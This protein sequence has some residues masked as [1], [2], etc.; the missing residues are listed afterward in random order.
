MALHGASNESRRASCV[1]ILQSLCEP[2]MCHRPAQKAIQR[3]HEPCCPCTMLI[4]A[5]GAADG[6]GGGKHDG[7]SSDDDLDRS[8]RRDRC[9][10]P[11]LTPSLRQFPIAHCRFN[12]TGRSAASS[13][14]D[15]ILNKT[16]RLYGCA[17][18]ISTCASR[19]G[20][21]HRGKDSERPRS[22]RHS[23]RS[24]SKD[25]SRSR[26]RERSHGRSRRHRDR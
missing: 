18:P 7:A 3:Y 12:D 9:A 25:R 10:E 5:C 20:H 26:S 11:L 24:R 6:P 17:K 21:R 19:D 16:L 4:S 14:P 13:R 1:A 23:R 22:S 2:S 8:K 15:D